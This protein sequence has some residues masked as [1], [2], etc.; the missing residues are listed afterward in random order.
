MSQRIV[1]QPVTRIEGHA[2]VTIH[3][4]EA[5][6]VSGAQFHVMEFRGFEKFCEGRPFS[7]MPALMARICGICPISHIIASSKAGDALLGV[8]IPKGAI[9]QRRLLTDAQIIQSHAL[10]FFHLSS[11]D[12]LLGFDSDPAKRNIFGV[13]GQDLAFAREG[14]RLRQFG[15]NLIERVSGKRVH[16]NWG[17]PG[18]VLGRVT[19]EL[20]DEFRSELPEAYTAVEHALAR[21]KSI[22]DRYPDEVAN[23]GAF[24][25]MFLGSVNR[26]GE[27]DYYDG[28]LRMVDAQGA[29]VADQLNPRRFYE[30]LEETAEPW[31]YMKFPYYKPMGYPD[32][33]YRVGPL[34]R[35]NVATRMGT[36]RADREFTE[37]R[38]RSAGAVCESFHFHL[39]RLIEILGALERIERLLDDPMLLSDDLRS[40]ALLNEEEGVGSCEAPRGVLF[41]RYRVDSNGLIAKADLLIATSQNNLALNRTVE[42]TARRFV[43]PTELNEGMLNR[44]E[45]AVRCY[46]PCLSCST[47]ALGQMPLVLE[48]RGPDG[49]LRASIAR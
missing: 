9:L 30:Y 19:A 10:S 34:A 37:F 13:A 12:L 6:Q 25:S 7:E 24:P 35:L 22:I 40:R 11:P 17:I 21:C 41:H 16:P 26:D 20:R 44:V 15:Q 33:M 31:S 36:E 14:I 27:P 23:M 49:G 4:D 18:G 29:I 48:V 43:R 32:G 1:I 38:Q 46:D 42:Q 8:R 47:H 45:A 28:R 3:V 5:G 39:A 2:K